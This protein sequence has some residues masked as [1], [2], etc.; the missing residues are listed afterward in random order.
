MEL[1]FHQKRRTQPIAVRRAAKGAIVVIL[2][3]S[4]VTA[5]Y[6]FAAGLPR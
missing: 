2:S 1:F 5:I 3:A 4:T 6:M